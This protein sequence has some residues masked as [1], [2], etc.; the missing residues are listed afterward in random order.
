MRQNT[1]NTKKGTL[2]EKKDFLERLNKGEI[3]KKDT[4]DIKNVRYVGYDITV[5]DDFL[6]LPKQTLNSKHKYKKGEKHNG[7]ITIKTGETIF[8]SS[9]EKV[10]IPWDLYGNI[11][12]KFFLQANGIILYTGLMI[13]PG[14]GLNFDENSKK[15]NPEDDERFHFFLFNG[16]DKDFTISPKKDRIATVQFFNIQEIEESERKTKSGHGNEF[17][18]D[19]FNDANNFING[20]TFFGSIESQ[21][22]NFNSNLSNKDKEILELKTTIASLEKGTSQIIMF[23]VYL[24]A[25]T[26]LGISLQAIIASIQKIELIGKNEILNIIICGLLILL[27]TLIGFSAIYFSYRTYNDYK[28]KNEPRN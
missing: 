20:I 11:G 3:F 8:V 9:N 2:L 28:Q 26:I 10:Q 21:V 1:P 12:T 23:G 17:I 5:A 4:W 7:K 22:S 27:F 6:I 14:F 24:V 16:G 25:V 18:E 15:W 13:E 19:M